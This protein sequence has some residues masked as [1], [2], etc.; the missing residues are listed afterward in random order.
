MPTFRKPACVLA[1]PTLAVPAVVRSFC[2]DLA[3]LAGRWQV[4]F[5]GERRRTIV[6]LAAGCARPE[7]GGRRRWTRKTALQDVPRA[8]VVCTDCPVS[9]TS[10]EEPL[11][12]P[13]YIAL[14]VGLLF[15]FGLASVKL[16]TPST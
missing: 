4:A 1:T 9:V 12:A 14:E 7:A 2:V 6:Q 3:M 13:L 15:S 5:F 11:P 8:V 16:P 10:I